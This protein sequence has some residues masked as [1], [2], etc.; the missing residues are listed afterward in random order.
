AGSLEPGGRYL[1]GKVGCGDDDFGAADIVV[2]K[3]Y[4]LELIADPPDGIDDTRDI[5]GKLDDQL[6]ARVS[7]SGFA[8]ENLDA[9]R[10]VFVRVVEDSEIK[11]DGLEDVEEL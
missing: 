10:P 8:R 6:R 9:G 2:R 11:R 1:L 4:L 3:D 7:G 5:A